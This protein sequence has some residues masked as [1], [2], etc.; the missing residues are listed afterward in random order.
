[1]IF[2]PFL[3]QSSASWSSSFLLIVAT[4]SRSRGKS[5]EG[6]RETRIFL[7]K[8]KCSM[9]ELEIILKIEYCNL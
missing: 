8:E 6:G 3:S 1:M 5:G 4:S 7:V 2:F 9:E